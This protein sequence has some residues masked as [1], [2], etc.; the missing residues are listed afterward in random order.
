MRDEIE[1]AELIE[2]IAGS[3]TFEGA[4]ELADLLRF[5]YSKYPERLQAKQIEDNHFGR[6]QGSSRHN[7]SHA[8][9][10][11]LDLRER[12]ERFLKEEPQGIMELRSKEK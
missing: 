8:R 2:T 1:Q 7:E 5:L 11:M 10:R 3:K 6:P 4:P 9:G 12:I